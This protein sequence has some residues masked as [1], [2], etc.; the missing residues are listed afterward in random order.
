MK[1]NFLLFVFL[2]ST[3]MASA[4]SEKIEA[5]IFNWKKA[6]V[7]KEKTGKKRAFFEGSTTH[8]DRFIVH[9][10]TLKP[11][12]A[13]HPSHTHADLEELVIVKEGQLKVTIE[14]KSSI[15]GPGS[16]ALIMPGDEHGFENAGNTKATYYVLRYHSRSPQNDAR[17]KAEGGSFVVNWEDTAYTPHDRGGVRHFF[18]RGTSMCENFEMHVTTLN[19]GIQS[20]PPHT[21][22]GEE[23]ILMITG[24]IEEYIDGKTDNAAIGDIV[25][26][27]SQVPHAP[28]N[29]G[30][31]QCTYFAFKW[32]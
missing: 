9:A 19:V 30:K 6:E 25:F 3:S 24:N 32:Y 29:I 2:V 31:K 18:D 10:T 12:L 21:H 5:Q 4:Q 8:F 11:G 23:I 27:A 7:N 13:P 17:G 20:H 16:I 14:G 28:T 1:I 26:L 22:V 15:L